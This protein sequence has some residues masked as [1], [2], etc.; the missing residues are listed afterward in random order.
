MKWLRSESRSG[1]S[2]FRSED[3][4]FEAVLDGSTGRKTRYVYLGPV[5]MYHW[6][7]SLVFLLCN[8]FTSQLLQT[9]TSL[10]YT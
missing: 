1:H 7:S 10:K 6:K 3:K 8:I 5:Q 2:L 4:L 9:V